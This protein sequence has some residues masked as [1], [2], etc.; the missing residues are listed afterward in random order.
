MIWSG[1]SGIG[2]EQGA[3]SREQGAGPARHPSGERKGLLPAPRSLL[4]DFHNNLPHLPPVTQP[5]DGFDA[6]L[7]RDR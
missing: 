5:L 4:P 7:Q 6:P 2:G 1:W 3:G